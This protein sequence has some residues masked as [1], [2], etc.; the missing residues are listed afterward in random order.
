A[1]PSGGDAITRSEFLAKAAL[2][3]AAIPAVGFT[4]GI[5]SGAHD[6]RVR[7]VTLKLKNLPRSFEGLRIAQVSD[8][9]SGSFY[10]KTAVKGGV[11]LLL[12]EKPDL[13][14]FT[15]D[16]VNDRAEE[17]KDYKAIFEKVKAPLGVYSTLG[18]HD[19]GD[20]A[21][22]SSPQAKR[23]NL[24]DLKRVHR[25]M[26]YDLLLDE[27]RFI[28]QNGDKIAILGI[29]N[30]GTGGFAQYG[31]LAKANAGTDEAAVKLL[32]SHDPSHWD[33]QVRTEFSDIDVQFAGHTHGMQF[34]IETPYFRWSPV[35][36]RY[37]QWA[38]LYK[39]GDQQLYVNRG[40]GF[41]GYPGRVGMPPEITVFELQK[42]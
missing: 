37:K 11:D 12:A 25:E 15:G 13:V 16:L 19:Y 18:N 7:K 6:Y 20:Y 35:Q 32:L 3:T 42:A 28:E 22:W 36:Y 39:E 5:I 30:W 41:L 33:A 26:G 2:V 10:N 8:I 29:Q 27:H 21:S 9:H 24:E 4:W 17:V 14:F 34:G 31:N 1:T 38:G 40:Y 23:Q